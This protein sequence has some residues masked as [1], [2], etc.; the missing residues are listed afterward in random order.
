[1]PVVNQSKYAVG[2]LVRTR[3]RDWVVVPS[4]EDEVLRLRPLSGSEGE[5]IGLLRQLEESAVKE[6]VFPAPEP[7]KAGDFVGSKLLRNAARLSLRSGAGPF[8]SLGRISVRPR[9]YQFVPLIMA[10]RLD[11]VR[12][13]IADDVGVGK[14]IEAGLIARE[15]LD[16]GEARR[17][18]VLCPPHLCDQWQ[19]EL[20]RHFHI[21]AEV[22][23]TSTIARLERQVPPGDISLYRYYPHLIIS[24]DFA[25]GDRRRHQ[26]LAD[27]PDLV[28]V[29]EVHAAADPGVAGSRDQQQRHQLLCEIAKDVKR[30]LLL[31]TATPHSGIEDSFRSLL[32]LL[33]DEF[34][35]L[36]LQTISEPQRKELA[37]QL[38]QRR[39]ADVTKWMGTDTPFPKR[40]AP[41]EETY[42]LSE[43]YGKLFQDV[44]EFTRQTV[45]VPGLQENRR[46]VRYWAALTL[47]RCLMS[48]PEAAVKAFA[49]REGD[50][51]PVPQEEGSEPP[52]ELRTRE[53][54]DSLSEAGTLDGVPEPAIEAGSRDLAPTDRAKLRAFKL[55][56][57]AIKESGR[58]P[59]IEKAAAIVLGM[60]QKGFH[61]IVFCR[62]VATA[63]YVAEQLEQRLKKHYATIR[64]VAVTSETGGDEEREAAIVNLAETEKRVLVAT[65]C[66]SEGVNLQDNF[67]AVLHYDLPWNPNRLE[68]RE[69]RVDR[70]MQK[71]KEV[72]A[73]V[74]YSPDNVIDGIVLE[75]LLRKAKKI[76]ETLGVRVSVPAESE[77]VVHAIV[78]AVF[79]NWRG[80]TEQ[81][82]L[83]FAGLEDVQSFHLKIDRE[84][85]RDK[86]SR[87]RFAQHA[88]KPDEVEQELKATDTVLGEPA[89]VRSFVLDAAD[90]LGIPATDRGSYVLI[91]P[92]E[93]RDEVKHKLGWQKPVK[94][95]F[96]S[97]PPQDVEN[98]V[99][100]GRNHPFVAYLSERILGRAFHP[101]NERENYRCGAAYTRSVKTRTVV[102]LLRVRYRLSRRGQP[103]QFAE[104]VITTGY[105]SEGG[106]V[107]WFEANHA[108]V[109]ELVEKAEVVGNISLAEK[110]QRI[111]A[112]LQEAQA[113]RAKLQAIADGH[114]RELEAAHHRLKQQIGGAKV[115]ATAY[116][117]D[118]LGIHILLPGGMV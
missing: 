1:M 106:D 25:K 75:V 53:V 69:G 95:V 96:D 29:D 73:V 67:D 18:C 34:G 111:E 93:L 84:A 57:E 40:V 62:F 71:R 26:F 85:L 21:H 63:K 43:E 59:K 61:P 22:V 118:I 87:T 50:A 17:L 24:I 97:P 46:R 6:S 19:T 16:R 33:R 77:S 104:E 76:Y 117:P 44:L 115:T 39:R 8:R 82:P 83:G 89:S 100:L 20:A 14:T 80:K 35:V 81:L 42:K 4:D 37:K 54:L 70:F 3:G 114:C 68:Q 12:V 74:L 60:L 55:R 13:L 36:D 15:L 110:Q 64:A 92:R 90:R 41:F 11:P 32:R 48:S 27:C 5:T 49:A 99:V 112:A 52:E 28:I 101:A 72:C 109:L 79:E 116:E 86:E 56:A 47:L 94:A 30:N 105:R 113:T 108:D 31:L 102:L 7:Y 2:S 51:A 78:K 23:R 88:I 103:D 58:D 66:L 9:P 98:A 10:M 107:R 45:Q 38:V 65:D 91:D